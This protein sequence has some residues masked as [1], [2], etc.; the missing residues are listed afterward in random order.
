MND[1]PVKAVSGTYSHQRLGPVKVV[2]RSNSRRI[3]GRWR[4][5]IF[6]VTVPRGVA[7]CKLDKYFELA[8]E[9]I[10]RARPVPRFTLGAVIDA[11]EIDISII[12][13]RL[14][15]GKVEVTVRR[16]NTLRGKRANVF[17]EIPAS[18]VCQM[19]TVDMQRALN[20]AIIKCCQL[21]AETYILPLAREC[22]AEIGRAPLRWFIKDSR[23][24][25]GRCGWDGSIQLSPRLMFLP[26]A[27]RRFVIFHEL[28]HLSEF[29]H[30]P[31]FH[32][33]WDCYLKGN[34]APLAQ[35]MKAFR[36]P[37]D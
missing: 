4:G 19:G 9:E 29:N 32:R 14:A 6:C 18:L 28:A 33:I 23:R 10:E 36:F 3:C 21:A 12:E 1:S 7:Q 26:D 2:A 34:R 22:A 16:N 35:R 20:T 37:V 8:M 25:L 24:A 31:E 5:G 17:I 30:S 27:L 15:E 11:H 13:S